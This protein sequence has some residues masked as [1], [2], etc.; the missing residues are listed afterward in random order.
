MWYTE[1]WFWLIIVGLIIF[2]IFALIYETS[3]NIASVWWTW[4][5]IILGILLIIIGIITY[6]MYRDK[7]LYMLSKSPINYEKVS[8]PVYKKEVAVVQ[9]PPPVPV[10]KCPPPVPVVKC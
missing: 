4:I 1:T 5:P 2:L 7:I 8:I 6:F 9:C 10:V 3:K